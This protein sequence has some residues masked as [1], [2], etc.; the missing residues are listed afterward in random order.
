MNSSPNRNPQETLQLTRM[1]Y[2]GMLSSIVMFAAIVVLV[3]KPEPNAAANV[4][5]IGGVLLAVGVGAFL[6]GMTVRSAIA[7]QA[8]RSR[9]ESVSDESRSASANAW[10]VMNLISGA[11][12]EGVGL[13]SVI[14]IIVTGRIEFL[15]VAAICA[16]ILLVMLLRAENS[17]RAFLSD[18]QDGFSDSMR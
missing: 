14:L 4:T 6:V 15:A 1:I 18:G 11:L 17:L 13:F 7:A 5:L 16:I 10:F 12:A 9:P 3:M 2:A 8:R